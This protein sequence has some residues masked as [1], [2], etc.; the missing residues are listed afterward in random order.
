M[1]K[2]KNHTSTVTPPQQKPLC[3]SQNV[4]ILDEPS[5]VTDSRSACS[6]DNKIF[7]L[8]TVWKTE[9]LCVCVWRKKKNWG[10]VEGGSFICVGSTW[11]NWL[12]RR[13]GERLD[14]CLHGCC[15]YLRVTEWCSDAGFSLSALSVSVW[16]HYMHAGQEPCLPH[17]FPLPLSLY[18]RLPSLSAFLSLLFDSPS[19]PFQLTL[20]FICHRFLH[21]ALYASVLSV[22]PC[23]FFDPLCLYHIGIWRLM[24]LTWS[25]WFHLLT[26]SV[27]FSLSVHQ[28]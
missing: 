23:L 13:V 19:S 1:P 21:I 3:D 14:F 25:L 18:H 17:P 24:K 9:R 16:K 22:S 5:I 2:A 7:L 10:F 26:C 11:V 6:T 15:V 4:V 12:N 28:P 8:V 27:L 20:L